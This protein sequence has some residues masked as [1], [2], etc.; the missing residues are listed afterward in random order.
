MA[1]TAKFVC[2]YFHRFHLQRVVK[3]YFIEWWENY[4]LPNDSAVR[5]SYKASWID[6]KFFDALSREYVVY[7][8][9]NMCYR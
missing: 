7:A 3:K 9:N 5:E 2:L 1:P 8:L 4:D 6:A